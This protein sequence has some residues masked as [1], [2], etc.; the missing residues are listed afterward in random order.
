MQAQGDLL[1]QFV[2]LAVTQGLVD[3]AKAARAHQQQRQRP[4][5]LF[6]RGDG[7]F[8]QLPQADSVRQ[9]GECIVERHALDHP[10]CLLAFALHAQHLD[11]VRQVICRVAQQVELLFVERIGLR[12][13]DIQHADRL[14]I[15][16]QRQRGR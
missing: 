8:K 10:F 3:L 2:A 13:A 15:D 5:L 9:L 4:S 7:L 6:R 16:S 11:A 12:S 1:Q 14:L